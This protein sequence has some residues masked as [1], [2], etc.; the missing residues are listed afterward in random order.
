MASINW[1]DGRLITL[2]SGDT[3]SS[4]GSL[5]PG[6]LYALFFYNAANNDANADVNVVWSNSQPPVKVTVPGTT[7]KQGL[8]ALC[9][10]SGDDTNTISAS[11]TSA[12]GGSQVQAFIGSV[13]MPTN[14][15]GINN[16]QLP[17]DGQKIAFKAFTRFYAVPQSHWYEGTLQSNVNQ[18]ISV[19]FKQNS[20]VVNIVNQLVEPSNVIKYAGNSRDSVTIN[21]ATTQT[22]PWSLQGNGNQFVWINADSIQNSQSATIAVQSLV[23]AYA[24]FHIVSAEEEAELAGAGPRR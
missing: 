22:V 23:A 17:L 16:T 14:T 15:S 1:N 4:V 6:Q 13:K 3:A 11:I 10:V 8:A 5:N 21:S 2:S 18:F 19:Q 7:Q 20:A 12:V 24:P 9:F